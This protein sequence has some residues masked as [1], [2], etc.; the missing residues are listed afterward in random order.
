MSNNEDLDVSGISVSSGVVRSVV[1]V[2]E[3]NQYE[4]KAKE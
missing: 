2:V 1:G 3:T 4:N